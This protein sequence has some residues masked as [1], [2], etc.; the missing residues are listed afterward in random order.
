M[1]AQVANQPSDLVVC[2]DDNDGFALFD[3]TVLNAQV[4]GAQSSIDYTVTYH[5]TQTDADND[6]N[7]ISSPYTN[8]VSNVQTIYIRVED[9]N[10]DNAAMTTVNLIVNPIPSPTPSELLPALTLCDDTN[11]GDG[12]E[13][14]DL[15]ENEL[16]IINGEVGQSVS[17]YITEFDAFSDSNVISNPTQFSNFTSP[18]T[19]YVK[20]TSDTTGCFAVVNFDIIVNPSPE[21]DLGMSEQN[22]CGFNS[23]T[24]EANSPFADAYN[25]YKN[26]FILTGETSSTLIVTESDIYQVQTFNTECGTSAFSELVTINLYEDAGTIEQQ[27][28]TVTCEDIL[29]DG[30]VNYDLDAMTSSL[31]Y[32]DGFTVSYYGNLV[33]ANQA[34]NALVS[35]YNSF[36]ET[37]IIRVED[38]DAAVNG[39]LGCRQL[40]LLDLIVDCED[41]GI[42]NVNAFFDIDEDSVFDM[43]ETFFSNGYFTYEMNNDGIIRTIDSSSGNF[44]IISPDETNT[45]DINYYF[46]DENNCFDI[47][48]SNFENI[49][50]LFGDEV[51]V[52]FPIINEQSCEDISVNLINSQAPRPG[53]NHF[54]YLVIENLGTVIT[55]G[56]VDYILD[57]LLI[58]DSI[59]DGVGYTTTLNPNGFSLDFVDLLP[60]QSIIVSISLLT[61]T[62]VNL[63]ALVTNSAIYT[64]STNDV[65]SENN[66]SFVT[67]QVIGSY[68]PNDKMESHGK[69]IVYDDFVTSDEYL[70]YTIRFQ[71]VGTAEAINVRI[72]D[73]LDSQLDETT[74][75]MIRS[76]HDYVASLID[77]NLEW[78]FDNINLPAEQDDAD[79]SNGFVYFKIK[80]NAGYAIGDI[81]ENTASIYFD[82]N[83]PIITN[84][85]QT[86]FVETLSVDSY[87]V[88][89]FTIFPN[90]AKEEVTI[91]LANSNFGTGKVNIYNIQGKVILKDIDINE[92][93]SVLDISNL[94]SG[95]YFVELTS[96]NSSIVQ[97]LIVN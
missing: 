84:T 19:I 22:Y 39:F 10:T 58:L 48:I 64:T 69:D 77:N 30:S 1:F 80:P 17:Y 76:S 49:S 88:A 36:G 66:E 93:T 86:E 31:G 78:N 55:S 83:E 28:I 85:F 11:T 2:D 50:V 32:G 90:P 42:I 20:V 92:N 13:I 87:D 16:I 44:K 59:I 34:E 15:T 68:D 82:F 27:I 67:E 21:V 52:D 5:E 41:I 26:G 89:S 18:Q 45:Y 40:A 24:L 38:N 8:I 81:I 7:A 29:P 62:S 3:L 35:P 95:L 96:G 97:K 74:F 94:E 75:Q 46:Y 70:Y 91:Q 61:P 25:W 33:D 63:G 73:V 37:L 60:Q 6:V 47:S 43:D 54:N 51:T 12:I 72:E 14:F 57:D 65:I 79:G 9:I 4:L 71:N 56:T 23:I 53:F